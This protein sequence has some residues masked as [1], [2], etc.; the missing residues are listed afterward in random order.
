MLFKSI[1]NVCIIWEVPVNTIV[2]HSNSSGILHSLHHRA[3]RVQVN[4]PSSPS[5]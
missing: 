4:P 3:L 5:V 1:S 2:C